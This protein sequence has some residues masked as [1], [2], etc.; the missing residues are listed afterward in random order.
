M[1]FR[2][3]CPASLVLASAMGAICALPLHGCGGKSKP[4]P[5]KQMAPPEPK[6]PKEAMRTKEVLDAF[7]SVTTPNDLA[8]YRKS[9][10]WCTDAYFKEVEAALRAHDK[11]GEGE[12]TEF[13]DSVEGLAL[14]WPLLKMQ[15]ACSLG[16][17]EELRDSLSPSMV[18]DIEKTLGS[19]EEFAKHVDP[20]SFIRLRPVRG[21]IADGAAVLFTDSEVPEHRVLVL[22]KVRGLWRLADPIR[23]EPWEYL[24]E[25]LRNDT[26]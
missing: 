23:M 13:I 17:N 8:E 3:L 14:R 15:L 12:I 4:M 11:A 18:K 10:S 19:V 7:G 5:S 9:L 1:R 25:P 24:M 16:R 26:Q 20:V 21:V 2:S 6:A 22:E